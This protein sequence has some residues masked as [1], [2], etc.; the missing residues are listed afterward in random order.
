MSLL[1]SINSPADLKSLSI[2]Q[3]PELAEE[4]RNYIISVVAQN[5]GHL[6][7]NLGVVDL[8]IAL[9]Y[10][11]NMPT[12]RLIFDVGHQCYTHKILTGRREDFARIRTRKGPSGFPKR[13]ESEY[14][15]FGAGHASTS[16]PAALGMAL[17]RD[18]AGKNHKVIAVIGDGSCTGGLTYEGLNHAGGMG[19]DML[20][21]LNDN[22]MS[23]SKNVGALSKYLTDI[24]TDEGYNKF[25]A[26]VWNFTE[27]LPQKERLRRAIAQAQEFIKG[28]LIPGQIFER[29]GFRYFGPIDG[30]DFQLMIKTL[31][32]IKDLH[33]PLLLHVLTKKGKGYSFAEDA[34]TYFHGV[35]A[36]DKQTGLSSSLKKTLPYTNV[37][38][39][40][41]TSLAETNDKICAITAAMTTGTGLTQFAQKFPNRFFDVGIAEQL[42]TMVS[43][44]LAADGYRPFFAVYSTFL[45]RGYD[46]VV[47]DVALQN[48]PVVFCIDRA[49]VVGEDGPTHHGAF[50]IP[51]L[52][53]V[54]KLTITAPKDGYELRQLMALAAGYESGP[55]VI[56]Y[57]RADIPETD[58]SHELIAFPYGT[59]ERLRDGDDLAILAVGSMVYP[60][61]KAADILDKDNIHATVINCRFLRPFDEAMLNDILSK[62]DKIITIEEGAIRGGFGYY[63]NAYAQENNFA[64]HKIKNLGI[65]DQF[66]THD[67]RE[68]LLAECGLNIEG[69]A[70]S[71]LRFIESQK[72]ANRKAKKN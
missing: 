34:P 43:A 42:G 62:H 21:I 67:S 20:I 65:P 19:R 2:E 5:G 31:N 53:H 24:I 4:I 56:R 14:D 37:F 54:P 41:L 57:P 22:T 59:W 63:I 38:G 32:N 3:L 9:H 36:F 52:M 72:L 7:S 10:V 1:Q 17:A 18:L 55:F 29:L 13:S 51:Y 48:L 61:W 45:Q 27:K 35:G 50:D 47:H 68:H 30:H 8:T 28:M 11:F 44:A 58:S 60:A 40:T 12:D 70:D 6:A 64:D 66:L 69:I 49:G 71:V 39:Q 46:Q 15:A 33:R 23:I 25:K 16:I 26:E